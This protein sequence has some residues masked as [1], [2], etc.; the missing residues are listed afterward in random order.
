VIFLLAAATASALI[1]KVFQPPKGW[2][3]MSLP[4]GGAVAA[5]W[6]APDYSGTGEN[7]LIYVETVPKGTTF[8]SLVKRRAAESFGQ[9]HTLASSKAQTTCHGTQPGWTLD[10]RLP[11]TAERTISQ[12]QHFAMRGTSVYTVIYTHTAGTPIPKVIVE[13]IDS[14]CPASLRS[15]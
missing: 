8:D 3:P 12:V 10:V 4:Q 11:V 7:I 2:A 5:G 6:A 14:L 15:G 13:S 9:G 1:H